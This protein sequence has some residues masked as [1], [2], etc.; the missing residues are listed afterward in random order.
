MSTHRYQPRSP[1]LAINPKAFLSLFAEIEEPENDERDDVTIVTIRGPLTQHDSWWEDSYEAIRG[2][3]DEACQQA[4]PVVVLSIDSPGGDVHGLFDTVRAIRKS[5]DDA[6][7][8]LVAH[9]EGQGCSAAYALATAADRIMASSTAEVGSIG[10]I[11]ARI[12]ETRALENVGFKFHLII[13][14]ARKADGWACAPMSKDE[15]AAAQADVDGLAAEFFQ[16]VSTARGISTEEIAAFE[17]ASFRGAAALDAGLVDELGSFDHLLA[18]LS[19]AQQGEAMDEEEKAREALRSI[20]ENEEKSEED[21]DK[22][23]K[24]LAAL[25]GEDEKEAEDEDEEPESEDDEEEPGAQDDDEDDKAAA[26]PGT[27]SAAAAGTLADH[28]VKL[29]DRVA[30]LEKRDR[31]STIK[32]MVATHG[33]VT[34]KMAKLVGKMSVKDAEAILAGIEKPKKPKLGEHAATA[35]PAKPTRG[36]GEETASQLPPD[37]A[38]AMRQ[39]M[40][41]EGEKFG[42]VNEG[43]VTMLGAPTSEGGES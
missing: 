5:C 19:G 21:R 29:E 34:P 13:S 11:A 18:S 24:A 2:R 7:K 33:G 31:V 25:D 20:A 6:G 35:Q 23:R 1:L 39:A 38:K 16:M 14:G 41:M 8:R 26:A 10:V 22:A 36:G 28:S 30:K 12:D 4:A 42:V 43:N 17:A 27:V 32:S 37:E 3:V 9:V 15:L 40:G